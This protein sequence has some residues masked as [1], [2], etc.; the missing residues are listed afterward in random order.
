MKLRDARARV[1]V[2]ACLHACACRCVCLCTHL[3]M[4]RRNPLSGALWLLQPLYAGRRTG[5]HLDT[6]G[7]ED[8]TRIHSLAWWQ[9]PC[10]AVRS[11]SHARFGH[12]TTTRA[13]FSVVGRVEGLGLE[14]R[15]VCE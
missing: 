12:E 1:S 10:G 5:G 8:S 3:T 13:P 6:Q 15:I 7:I 14:R 4:Q 11:A 9:Q 2:C